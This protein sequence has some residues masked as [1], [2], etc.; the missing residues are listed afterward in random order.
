[1][2]TLRAKLTLDTAEALFAA[3]RAKQEV[4]GVGDAAKDAGDKGTIS[5]GSFA[6]GIGIA[7]AAAG[8]V[9]VVVKKIHDQMIAIDRSLGDIAEHQRQR[10]QRVAQT[11]GEQLDREISDVTGWTERKAFETRHR[12]GAQYDIAP[13]QVGEIM[14][15]VYSLAPSGQAEPMLDMALKFARAR[16]VGGDTMGFIVP[17]LSSQFGMT[18]VPAMQRGLAQMGA[19]A[20]KSAYT[21]GNFGDILS[22]VAPTLNQAGLTYEQQLAYIGAFSAFA[23]SSP[24][25]TTGSLEILSRLSLK[26]KDPM[27]KKILRRSGYDPNTRNLDEI[28]LAL[29]TLTEDEIAQLAMESGLDQRV[30]RNVMRTASPMFKAKYGEALAMAQG[31]NW[32]Q[33]VEGKFAGKVATPEAESRRRGYAAAIESAVM[34]EPGTSLESIQMLD[35][36]RSVVRARPGYEQEY[37]TWVGKEFGGFFSDKDMPE[38]DRRKLYELNAVYPRVLDRLTAVQGTAVGKS[39]DSLV[40]VIAMRH[41]YRLEKAHDDAN[42]WHMIGRQGEYLERYDRAMRDAVEFLNRVRL[43]REIKGEELI[44]AMPGDAAGQALRKSETAMPSESQRGTADIMPAPP[45]APTTAPG[46]QVS[47]VQVHIG[48]FYG[49]TPRDIANNPY[50]RTGL[51]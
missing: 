29:G 13:E 19:V 35:Q 17:L 30:I 10:M 39:S 50:V 51:G 31:A 7:A 32:A 25:M 40:S 3:R 44:G 20:E 23:P 37:T 33:D 14:K 5:F 21:T 47:A 4:K 2:K 24:E 11:I 49:Q 15:R 43:G 38:Q 6:K 36:L 27:L 28:R 48:T 26:K 45:P 22:R 46:R 41:R 1:V 16:A 8:T 18:G 34:G 9:L 42:S 12:Y